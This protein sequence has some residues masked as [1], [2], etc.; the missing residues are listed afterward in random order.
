MLA[1]L[2]ALALPIA[3]S[4]D[5]VLGDLRDSGPAQSG[6]KT[7]APRTSCLSY[8]DC[9]SQ[10]CAS[11]ICVDRSDWTCAAYGDC[12]WD[13]GSC[14]AN[15]AS[16]STYQD[17]CSQDCG[18]GACLEGNPASI[19]PPDAGENGTTGPGHACVISGSCARYQ[20]CCSGNCFEGLCAAAPRGGLCAFDTPC[21]NYADCCS[22]ECR[23]GECTDSTA[24]P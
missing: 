3:C 22:F 13:G 10:D 20:D 23:A 9:A 21:T 14:R 5:L 17:C 11:G 2:L 15:V 18:L 12:V 6:S 4:Y 1:A 16:C 8:Q 7:P 24:D 19:V